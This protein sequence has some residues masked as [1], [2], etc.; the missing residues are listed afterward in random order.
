[1]SWAMATG[2]GLGGASKTGYSDS[3][4]NNA[5]GS[6]LPAGMQRFIQNPMQDA[7]DSLGARRGARQQTA[8]IAPQEGGS[9]NCNK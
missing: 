8:G 7:V 1:M 4:T 3:N 2:A 6:A 5:I 9:C